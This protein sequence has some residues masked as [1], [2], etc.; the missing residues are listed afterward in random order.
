L[1]Q[2]ADQQRYAGHPD[3]TS[4]T[5]DAVAAV[6]EENVDFMKMYFEYI[7]NFDEAVRI[8]EKWQTKEDGNSSGSRFLKARAQDDRHS[9]LNLLGYLLLP[10]QRVPRYKL[11]LADLVASTDAPSTRLRAGYEKIECLAREI[12]DRKAEMEG[13]KRLVELER[14]VV[15]PPG[16]EEEYD[17]RLSSTSKFV[18]PARRLVK[19][20]FIHVIVRRKKVA[21]GLTWEKQLEQKC[22]A[23][24][25]SDKLFLVSL[26]LAFDLT[27]VY[28]KS[29]NLWTTSFLVP[30]GRDPTR[31]CRRH[32]L[33]GVT[34]RMASH[35][36]R[37]PYIPAL[38]RWPLAS[39]RRRVLALQ[40]QQR[41]RYRRL[42]RSD[43]ESHQTH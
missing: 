19:E 41:R 14:T 25:C 16:V 2:A 9:Q 33:L 12:N 5:C 34:H 15:C 27:I 4:M 35:G 3:P 39:N 17:G 10:V 31:Q 29:R 40:M 26:H 21:G 20:E 30:V 13:R 24:S 43:F 18:D 42:A 7:N 6:F 32:T 28:F 37:H 11:L 22:L 36:L 1:I 8:V 38:A 23:I